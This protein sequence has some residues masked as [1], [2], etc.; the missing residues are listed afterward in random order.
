MIKCLYNLVADRLHKIKRIHQSA[1]RAVCRERNLYPQDTLDD[2][3]PANS[4]KRRFFIWSGGADG[5]AHVA[6]NHA[7]YGV[8][9]FESFPLH[10]GLF[11]RL[12]DH[13]WCVESLTA[14]RSTVD[15]LSPKEQMGV[16]FSP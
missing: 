4:P 5:G 15:W 10:K 14:G 9:G 16:R 11:P 12:I 8:R 3:N 7:P 2:G 1:L 6:V 13:R